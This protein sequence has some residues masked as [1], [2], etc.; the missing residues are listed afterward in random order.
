[1]H[2]LES[3]LKARGLRVVAVTEISPMDYEEDKARIVSSAAEN[4]IHYPCLLDNNGQWMLGVGIND[5]P[6]FAVI[7]RDGS[8]A[9]LQRGK[10]LEGSDAQRALEAAIEQELAQP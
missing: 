4:D 2:A 5:V 9:H 1:M 8:I 6:A 3:K 10:M 7:A